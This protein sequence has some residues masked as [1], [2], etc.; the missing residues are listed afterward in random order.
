VPFGDRTEFPPNANESTLSPLATNSA[1]RF[2][3][4][5]SVLDQRPALVACLAFAAPGAVAS[6]VPARTRTPQ[7]PMGGRCASTDGSRQVPTHFPLPREMLANCRHSNETATV[8][9]PAIQ[10]W[11]RL[12]NGRRHGPHPGFGL[13][14]QAGAHWIQLR[15]AQRFPEMR[16]IQWAGT[17][18]PCQT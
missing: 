7:F 14:H 5:R 16:L 9:E 4:S 13:G 1:R 3:R 12:R 18:A 10:D 2:R 11:A 17:G 15:I 8:P 6:I